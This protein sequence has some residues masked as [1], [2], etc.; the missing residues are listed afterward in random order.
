MYNPD[1]YRSETAYRQEQ[2]SRM[3]RPIRNRRR[4]RRDRTA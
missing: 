4:T 3:W 1:F 2:I